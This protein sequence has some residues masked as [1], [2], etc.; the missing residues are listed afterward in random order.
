MK[1]GLPST[2]NE[3]FMEDRPGAPVCKDLIGDQVAYFH[4]EDAD[5]GP[6]Q[7]FG[8]PLYF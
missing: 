1:F 3:G 4:G 2:G 6:G 5:A 8:D 7:H